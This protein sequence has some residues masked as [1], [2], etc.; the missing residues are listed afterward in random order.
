MFYKEVILFPKDH[1][2]AEE[3]NDISIIE[4]NN[5]FKDTCEVAVGKK[6]VTPSKEVNVGGDYMFTT[7]VVNSVKINGD[8]ITI[9]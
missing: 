4:V 5:G 9:V 2:F 1:I 6:D 3:G 8:A 7:F